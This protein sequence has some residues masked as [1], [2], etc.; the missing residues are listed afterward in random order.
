LTP[1]KAAIG[2]F[3][4]VIGAVT[5]LGTAG[6]AL[7]SSEKP[8]DSSTAPLL[9]R[10]DFLG[11]IAVVVVAALAYWL[12]SDL[13]V[14]TLG[15]MGPGMLPKALAVLLG[16]LGLLLLA[17]SFWEAGVQLTGSSLRGPIFVF[18]GLVAFGLAVRPLGLVVAGPLAIFISA[19]ASDEVKWIETVVSAILTTLFCI[20]LFKFALGLPIPLAPW[21]LGY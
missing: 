20:V 18:G 10:Q 8:V 6:E 2:Y 19:F 11:G 4:Y 14:G 12:G 15:G 13:A 17:G 21:F 9:L 16:A 7:M 5:C 3:A 1:I